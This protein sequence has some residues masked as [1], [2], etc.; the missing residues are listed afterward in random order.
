MRYNCN[1][2]ELCNIMRCFECFTKIST[3]F[4]LICF[5][6]Y[7]SFVICQCFLQTTISSQGCSATHH[8]KT[9]KS[10]SEF[11]SNMWSSLLSSEC[12]YLLCFLQHAC[13]ICYSFLFCVMLQTVVVFISIPRL[14]GKPTSEFLEVNIVTVRHVDEKGWFFFFFLVAF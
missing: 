8:G 12:I 14:R 7:L 1:W 3:C 6:Q 9:K 13:I 11:A 4:L 2:A 10:L 5:V